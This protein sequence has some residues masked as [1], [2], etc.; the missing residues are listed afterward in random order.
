MTARKQI[1][2][3][4]GSPVV[5]GARWCRSCGAITDRIPVPCEEHPDMA[6]SDR[7][8]VCGCPLCG[9]CLRRSG[10]RN[11]CTD[12]EAMG[13][14]WEPVRTVGSSFVAD[15]LER[16]LVLNGVAAR[17]FDHSVFVDE[18]SGTPA[19]H[20]WVEATQRQSAD[21][22]LRQLGIDGIEEE[23]PHQARR[24]SRPAAVPGTGSGRSRRSRA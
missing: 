4:C 14:G 23:S 18:P 10:A 2:P 1:C 3:A 6:A 12:H 22:L 17:S 13:E 15:M 9:S 16:N 5:Q 19:V 8:V 11:T 21:E 7:C 20:V 24:R